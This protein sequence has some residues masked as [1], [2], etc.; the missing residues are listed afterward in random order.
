MEIFSLNSRYITN[1][2]IKFQ[3]KEIDN[4]LLNYNNFADLVFNYFFF[5]KKNREINK[6]KK[7][8]NVIFEEFIK[9]E[10]Y[11]EEENNKL[12]IKTHKKLETS[13]NAQAIIKEKRKELLNEL[14]QHK[15][16]SI[17]AEQS[18]NSYIP[19]KNLSLSLNFHIKYVKEYK[20]YISESD[21]KIN[22][23]NPAPN[24]NKKD[25]YISYNESPF[26]IDEKTDLFIIN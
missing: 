16:I 1:L 5:K 18:F 21:T 22:Y 15:G 13:E 6:I 23:H 20:K 25:I 24:P 10:A 14:H 8:Q 7:K 17:Y 11:Q 3:N 19:P 12:K 9:K 4:K 26:I 2:V